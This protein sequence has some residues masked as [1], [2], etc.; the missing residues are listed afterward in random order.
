MCFQDLPHAI[1]L[2]AFPQAAPH[3]Q[4]GIYGNTAQGW[5]KLV[6]SPK[7]FPNSSKQFLKA[8]WLLKVEV[9]TP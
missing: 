2:Q 5:A 1:P 6:L 3:L 9:Y 8:R 4:A 7:S